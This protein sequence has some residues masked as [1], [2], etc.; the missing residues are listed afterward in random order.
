MLVNA[1]G[2]VHRL[3]ALSND[4]GVTWGPTRVM[5]NMKNPFDGCEGSLM[6]DHRTGL[7]YFSNPW[8]ASYLRFNLT[9]HYSS[10]YG[11]SW[12]FLH[13]INAGRSGYSSMFVLQQNNSMGMLYERSTLPDRIF[14]PTAISFIT[15][16]LLTKRDI[17]E[18]S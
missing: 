5:R 4:G 10:D 6:Q 7:L 11:E 16:P 9:V 8:N 17:R 15:F 14:V 3:Q 1:R 18:T 2:V 13:L 12:N